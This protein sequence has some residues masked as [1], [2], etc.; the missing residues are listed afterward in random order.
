MSEL[1][2]SFYMEYTFHELAPL[3]FFKNNGPVIP[4]F[5]SRANVVMFN[6]FDQNHVALT[7]EWMNKVELTMGANILWLPKAVLLD[8]VMRLKIQ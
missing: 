4:A 1:N 2:C 7:E 6:D 3:N 5:Y 8:G